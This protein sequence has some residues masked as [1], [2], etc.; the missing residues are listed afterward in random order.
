MTYLL[1]TNA[2]SDL[3][4]GSARIE[5]WISGLPHADR[6][7][8]CA[9][10]R[11]EILFG[12]GRLPKG[13]RRTELE[14]ASHQFLSAFRCEAVPQGAADYYA[15]LKLARQRSGLALDENDL[16]VAATA[17]ALTA[18][19]VSRD[20]DFTGIEGLPLLNLPPQ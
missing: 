11:G 18:T 19:L 20:A 5:N 13:K 4:R 1:D 8:T 15:V 9:I 7:V 6:L 16:W 2:I 14:E 17:L 10:V 12:I 3:M